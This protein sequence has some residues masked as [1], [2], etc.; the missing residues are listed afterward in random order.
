VVRGLNTYTLAD[1][2][3][4]LTVNHPFVVLGKSESHF[5]APVRVGNLMK[6]VGRI[7]EE[8]GR[9]KTVTVDV[10]VEGKKVF[11]GVFT[12]YALEKHVLIESN[13]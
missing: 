13:H 9:K 8:T 7:T 4:M 11:T 6:A 3:A 1:Y 2:T 12:C 5:I 10:Q